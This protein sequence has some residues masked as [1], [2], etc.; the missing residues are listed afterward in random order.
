MG[1]SLGEC[2]AKKPTKAEVGEKGFSLA[3][4]LENSGDS[5]SSV[6]PSSVPVETLYT[7]AEEKFICNNCGHLGRAEQVN[8]LLLHH[9]LQKRL[10]GPLSGRI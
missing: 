1:L 6:S 4:A 9:L 2:G 5:Q 3:R 8:S 7:R 10:L